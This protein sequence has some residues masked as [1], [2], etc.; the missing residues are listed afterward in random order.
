MYIFTNS[1]KRNIAILFLGFDILG[2]LFRP[3]IE[4]ANT[5]FPKYRLPK[6]WIEAEGI[7]QS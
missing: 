7:D 1:Q 5:I 2:I 6:V 3:I 4:A